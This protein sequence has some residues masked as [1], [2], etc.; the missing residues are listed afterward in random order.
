MQL[1]LKQALVEDKKCHISLHVQTTEKQLFNN[2]TLCF[3]EELQA[4][5]RFWK[6]YKE[7]KRQQR[8]QDTW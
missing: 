3:L 4:T 5:T 1:S 8:K 7:L 2:V 6:V